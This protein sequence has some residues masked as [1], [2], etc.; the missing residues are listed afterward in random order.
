VGKQ[1]MDEYKAAKEA[2]KDVDP[3][4]LYD[5]EQV[6]YI[7]DYAAEK[8]VLYLSEEERSAFTDAKNALIAQLDE[9]KDTAKI[10]ELF[11]T[12]K[13]QLENAKG[14]SDSP[15]RPIVPPW[16]LA[17]DGG[18]EVAKVAN[19]VAAGRGGRACPY[20]SREAVSA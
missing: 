18:D 3:P 5:E 4:K 6:Q 14:T 19:R 8:H 1:K 17:S 13:E 11:N 16:K 12:Y 10:T 9:F 20:G 2:G 7:W 15:K